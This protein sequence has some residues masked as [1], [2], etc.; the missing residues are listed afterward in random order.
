[1]RNQKRRWREQKVQSS[2]SDIIHAQTLGTGST[3]PC[4]Y[5]FI[6]IRKSV[7]YKSFEPITWVRISSSPSSAVRSTFENLVN[8]DGPGLSRSLWVTRPP[9]VHSL[10]LFVGVFSSH[11]G[12]F[13]NTVISLLTR[14]GIRKQLSKHFSFM[15]MTNN[16][17][18]VVLSGW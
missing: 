18:Y 1:M 6:R 10:K 7:E 11:I 12:I 9:C 8:L 15:A 2:V 4:L 5:L 17:F 3:S 16:D 13:S 14:T